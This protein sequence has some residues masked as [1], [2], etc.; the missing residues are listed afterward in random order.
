MS[1]RHI[2]MNKWVQLLLVITFVILPIILVTVFL[3]KNS[4]E[5]PCTEDL[6]CGGQICQGG[7][8]VNGCTN[9]NSCEIKQICQ[10]GRCVTGCRDD[11]QCDRTYQICENNKCITGCRQDG[12]CPGADQTCQNNVC[13]TGCLVDGECTSGSCYAGSCT[14]PI[15]CSNSSYC[16]GGVCINYFCQPRLTDMGCY[17]APG[18]QVL[19]G[20]SGS[21]LASGIN[22]GGAL[23]AWFDSFQS[24]ISAGGTVQVPSPVY[25]AVYKPYNNDTYTVAVSW[26]RTL[27]PDSYKT[28]PTSSFCSITS[29]SLVVGCDPN[30]GCPARYQRV[31]RYYPSY[32]LGP[33]AG[34]SGGSS[35]PVSICSTYNDVKA[36]SGCSLNIEGSVATSSFY[37][38][39]TDLKKTMTMGTKCSS[40]VLTTE[41]CTG[42]YYSGLQ[43]TYDNKFINSI[44][45]VCSNGTVTPTILGKAS[46]TKTKLLCGSGQVMTGITGFSGNALDKLQV[47]CGYR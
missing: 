3:S 36:L 46:G 43:V 13:I 28:S 12:D 40:S 31:Y 25:L 18:I 17:T 1:V 42:E 34:G 44:Q 6:D 47:V 26:G 10:A 21:D 20:Y 19:P 41:T 8:C 7:Q 15:T 4:G 16:P 11:G 30:S 5:E 27:P 38:T 23:S 14:I 39:C 33:S 45:G 22:S 9:D 24:M 2:N 37:G 35:M 32:I 29:G